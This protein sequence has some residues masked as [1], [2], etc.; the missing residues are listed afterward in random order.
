MASFTRQF[1]ARTRPFVGPKRTL[2]VIGSLLLSRSNHRW[3]VVGLSF[4]RD[5]KRMCDDQ[6]IG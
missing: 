2:N 6:V 1:F 5:Q 4:S 3:R